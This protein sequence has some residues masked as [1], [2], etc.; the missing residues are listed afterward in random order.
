M[1][2]ERGRLE[3]ALGAGNQAEVVEGV[4]VL[5]FRVAVICRS[6]HITLELNFFFTLWPCACSTLFPAK[7][8]NSGRL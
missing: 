5:C 8:K 6:S 7:S 3:A 4:V 2:Q 1:G